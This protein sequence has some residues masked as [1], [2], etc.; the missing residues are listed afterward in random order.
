MEQSTLY[1]VR[2]TYTLDTRTR[3]NRTKNLI[4]HSHALPRL[5]EWPPIK[6]Y[7]YKGVLLKDPEEWN[8]NPDMI[9]SDDESY[10]F[11]TPAYVIPF[12]PE[13]KRKI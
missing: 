10:D 2:Q 3:D 11:S 5:L 6:Y 1:K 9:E 12:M 8:G 4:I 7:T 13:K